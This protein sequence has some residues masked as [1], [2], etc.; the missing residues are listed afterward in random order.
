MP[1]AEVLLGDDVGRVLRPGR[2]EL[3]AA[4]LERG[5]LGIADDRV[6]EL[7]LDLVE[8][9]DS[10]RRVATLDRDSGLRAVLSAACVCHLESLSSCND[11]LSRFN[12]TEPVLPRF[13]R[14]RAGRELP[15]FPGLSPGRRADE[16]EVRATVELA[17][18]RLRHSSPIRS[19]VSSLAG[20]VGRV[21]RRSLDEPLDLR[22]RDRRACAPR[23][24][25]APAQLLRDRTAGARRLASS[26][27]AG[28][29]SRRSNVVKRRP[30][31]GHS[32]RRRGRC[33]AVGAAATPGRG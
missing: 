2:R 32:R 3:D 11:V 6:A 18:G 4:L 5:V 24:T 13:G 20:R 33:A 25:S 28:R 1:A 27:G 15:Q 9:V 22:P 10:G 30:Q 29:R 14:N 19:A 31:A 17:A 21:P 16:L 23:A 7:P 12:W 8:R 26:R